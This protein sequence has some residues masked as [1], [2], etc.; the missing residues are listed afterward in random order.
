MVEFRKVTN[1]HS[2]L[3]VGGLAGALLW[4]GRSAAGGL[5]A[6]TS[7]EHLRHR[8]CAVTALL[9]AM[10]PSLDLG[11]ALL[12]GRYMSAVARIEVSQHRV[13]L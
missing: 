5:A 10:R 2:A 4:F 11:R 6:E 13:H 3:G 8:L 12:R 7:L 1:G 9:D